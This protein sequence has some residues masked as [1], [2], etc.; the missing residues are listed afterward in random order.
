MA[1]MRVTLLLKLSF[2]STQCAILS[3]WYSDCF[4]SLAPSSF[5][6]LIV[7]V[8]KIRVKYLFGT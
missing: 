2:P 1:F 6:N 8:L 3:K 4:V 7:I 5:N